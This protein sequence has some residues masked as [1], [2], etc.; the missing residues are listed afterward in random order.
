MRSDP[1]DVPVALTIGRRKLR[2]MRQS[3]GWAVGYNAT[4]LPI[5]AGAFEPRS[6]LP[7]SPT[8]ARAG[9]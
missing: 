6:S 3:P 5:A 4:R 8:I 9:P 1:L 7:K 2:K